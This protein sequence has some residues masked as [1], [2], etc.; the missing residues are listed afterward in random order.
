MQATAGVQAH[1]ARQAEGVVV[2]AQREAAVLHAL[3]Q[4]DSKGLIK[5]RSPRSRYRN[6]VHFETAGNL[7][8]SNSSDLPAFYF[9]R[10]SNRPVKVSQINQRS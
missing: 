4:P 7:N 8:F 2:Q 9:N 10:F 5:V 1:V 6:H 3:V